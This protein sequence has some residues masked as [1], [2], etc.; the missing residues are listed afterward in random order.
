[1]THSACREPRDA[2]IVSPTMTKITG[3][4]RA[5]AA[6]DWVLHQLRGLPSPAP[7]VLAERRGTE[8]RRRVWWSLIYGSFNPRRRNA[9][10]RLD[11][12]RYHTIDWHAA[13]LFAIA[14]AILLLS[15]GDA[16]MTLTLLSAGAEEINPVMAMVVGGD[17]GIFVACK[18]ALTGVSVVMLA[19]LARYR[20]MR[21]IRVELAL[22]A[23]LI[24]YLSLIGYE[25]WML[26]T[27]GVSAI[28]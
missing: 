1:M 27:L 3:T 6:N 14:I 13:H 21:T 15:V 25:F 26:K 5:K 17:A 20:F 8:R 18:M 16:F 10:R 24:G 11:E 2:G 12:V 9:P 4:A 19:F 23:V 22:Y 28:F 7:G